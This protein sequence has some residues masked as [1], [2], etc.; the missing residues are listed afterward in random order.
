M[1]SILKRLIP[2]YV[3]FLGFRTR[4]ALT[5][6]ACKLKYRPFLIR[7][8]TTDIKVFRCIFVNKEF[9][10]PIKVEP[11][12]IVDAGA[13]TGLST[14]YFANRYPEAKII[15]IE[16]EPSNFDTLVKNTQNL[17]KVSRINAGLWSKSALLKIE[18]GEVGNWG[19]TVNE[20]PE[21]TDFHTHAITMD[22][23][24]KLNVIDEI[25]ILKLDIEGA[26]KELF[27]RNYQSWIH[28]VNV[29]IIELHDRFMPGCTESL[30]NAIDISKWDE[31]KKGEKVVLVR[32]K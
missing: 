24:F 12:F 7:K 6:V 17:E 4:S 29:I 31:Y 19:F 11:K 2:N 3:K 13:Y 32:K 16:P 8:G 14:L 15:A 25:D 23:V 26:E 9:K 27:S 10:L 28:K 18:E 22:D 21:N 20:V 1:K 5:Y 30:Y